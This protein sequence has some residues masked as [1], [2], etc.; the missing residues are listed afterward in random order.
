MSPHYIGFAIGA[1][2]R[3]ATRNTVKTI[4]S[5]KKYHLALPKED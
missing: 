4:T 3:A 2:Y 5:D 1:S